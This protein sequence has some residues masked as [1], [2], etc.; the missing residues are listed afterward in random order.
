VLLIEK[1]HD[2][3]LTYFSNGRLI[4][5]NCFNI[6]LTLATAAYLYLVAARYTGSRSIPVIF[7]LT[8]FYCTFW[9]NY[10]RAQNSDIYQTLF[11]LGFYHHFTSYFRAGAARRHQILAGAYLGA[12]ILVKTFFVILI[13]IVFSFV[14]V[15]EYQRLDPNRRPISFKT[16]VTPFRQ[17]AWIAFPIVCAGCVLLAVNACKYGSP[18]E[19]GWGG[20]AFDGNFLVGLRGFLFERRHSVFIYFPVFT[21]ALPGYPVF[22]RK[23]R[24]DGLLFLSIGLLIFLFCC[25]LGDW[26]GG[27]GYGPRYML[28]YLPLLSLPFI[29]TMEL[30]SA[31]RRKIWVAAGAAVI[32]VAL[33]FSFETQLRV[34]AVPFFAYYR[35]QIAFTALRIP[36]VD[37]YFTDRTLGGV[38]ADLLAFKKSKPM[39][40]L[41]LASP[42][43]NARGIEK[44]TEIVRANC[45]SNYYFWPDPSESADNPAPML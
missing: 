25:K 4:Y 32:G 17:A 38:A 42:V 6:I 37:G 40:L 43:L 2:G 24:L 18:F 41:Q 10:L 9:W 1:W 7:V 22:L 30:I 21:F 31:N 34:N 15:V 29:D 13:P 39:P 16:A 12:M 28:P 19:T 20:P 23:H 27:W 26:V 36:G 3:N 35:L 44:F 8:A 11:L 45:V 5:L 14:A 33:I